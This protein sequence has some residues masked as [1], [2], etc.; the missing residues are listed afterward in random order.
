MID[1]YSSVEQVPLNNGPVRKQNPDRMLHIMKASR[2]ETTI[3]PESVCV[4]SDKIASREIKG[5]LIIVPIATGIGEG[6][7]DVFTVNETGRA[8]WERLDGERTLSAVAAEIAALYE[9]SKDQI[10]RDVLEF[11]GEL[12]KRNFVVCRK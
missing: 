7:D 3:S 2:M 10:I 9:G 1:T 6:E 8:I 12:I 11:A 5:M 4:P